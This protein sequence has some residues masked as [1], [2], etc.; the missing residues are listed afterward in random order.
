MVLQFG[1]LA[2]ENPAAGGGLVL[3]VFEGREKPAAE[4]R[5]ELLGNDAD[6]LGGEQVERAG[7]FGFQQV[8]EAVEGFHHA[9]A[10][11]GG[12]DEVAGLGGVERGD[13]GF[14]IADFTDEEDVR[15]L[16]Q[17]GA[18]AGGEAVRVLADLPLGEK[19][20]LVF[21]QIFDRVLQRDDVA[22]EVVVDPVQ[23]GGDGGGLAGAGR[24][25]DENQ[26]VAA[27]H[28]GLEQFGRQAELARG[29]GCRLRIGRRTAARRPSV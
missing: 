25:G 13:G 15:T 12:D 16:A 18:Q 6:E 23:A 1:Q 22:G 4:A 10:V 21:K 5:Q 19:R 9:A 29:R 11:Q 2:L 24:A 26:A 14:R 8:G 27:L 28:P 17:R 20:K 7:G 3:E